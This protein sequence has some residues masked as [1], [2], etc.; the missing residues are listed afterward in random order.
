[1]GDWVFAILVLEAALVQAPGDIAC[2]SR[3][4]T[5]EI[6]YSFYRK[7][8]LLVLWQACKCR[9]ETTDATNPQAILQLTTSTDLVVDPHKAKTV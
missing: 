4:D 7:E 8:K 3:W 9:C 2:L 6:S 1:M 5:L